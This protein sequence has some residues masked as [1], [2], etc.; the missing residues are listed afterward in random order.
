MGLILRNYFKKQIKAHL[1]K[2]LNIAHYKQE[3][4]LQRND[5]WER[6]AKT[7]QWSARGI[8]Q[9]H[10]WKHQALDTT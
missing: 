8:H 9:K 7:Q 5:L 4:I 3:G 10:F 1:F 6:A 2:G